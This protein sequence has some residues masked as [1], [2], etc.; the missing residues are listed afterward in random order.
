MFEHWQ[1]L[2]YA[3]EDDEQTSIALLSRYFNNQCSTF[4]NE[5]LLDELW[6]ND[7]KQR[8]HVKKALLDLVDYFHEYLEEQN[9]LNYFIHCQYRKITL[10]GD[11]GLFR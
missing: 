2:V 10:V 8:N 3:D 7:K 6:L 9:L 11:H 4:P 1:N 5:E